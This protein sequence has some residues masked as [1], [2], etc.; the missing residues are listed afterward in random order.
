MQF[1]QILEFKLKLIKF[2]PN[3]D[4]IWINPKENWK[5]YYSLRPARSPQPQWPTR[6]WPSLA[7]PWEALR[8]AHTTR[9][10]PQRAWLSVTQRGQG[11]RAHHGELAGAQ[12]TVK[13]QRL[14]RGNGPWTAAY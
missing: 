12:W 3:S 8:P 13:G 1:D 9:A 10:R 14:K 11:Q 6:P 2:E 7:G 5:G 4:L